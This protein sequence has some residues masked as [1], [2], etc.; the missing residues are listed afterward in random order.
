[1]SLTVMVIGG[2]HRRACRP[3]LACTLP[4]SACAVYRSVAEIKALGVGINL[5]PNA[6]REL[7]ELGLADGLAVT[8]IE[9]AELAYHNRH[10]QLI[11]S[12]PRGFAPAMPGHNTPSIAAICR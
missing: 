4:V 12:E 11:W 3:R 6:V 2:G 7:I 9:T 10:G 5:Q 8:A 1:M